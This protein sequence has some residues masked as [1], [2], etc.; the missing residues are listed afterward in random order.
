MKSFFGS[1]ISA[2]GT[3]REYRGISSCRVNVSTMRWMSW[4]R[5]RFLLPSLMKPFEASIMKMP[6]RAWA[7]SLSSTTMQ[8]GMPVP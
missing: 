4:A 6:F 1:L 2:S 8:A 3:M 7:F 5:R